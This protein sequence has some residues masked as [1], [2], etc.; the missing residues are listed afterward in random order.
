MEVVQRQTDLGAVEPGVLLGQPALSLNVEHQVAASDKLDH[1]EESARRLEAG[2]ET[3]QELVI[4]G[5]L[6]EVLLCLHQLNLDHLHGV[7]SPGSLQLD[8]KDLG[9]GSLAYDHVL[10]F[11]AG[12]RC[13]CA[14]ISL[15]LFPIKI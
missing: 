1:K 11:I 9:V 5:R 8:H 6:E 10:V 12:S 2:V 3:N 15:D 13:S 4:G 14:F 7:D